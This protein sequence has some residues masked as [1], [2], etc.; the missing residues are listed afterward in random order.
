MSCK[1]CGNTHQENFCPVCGERKF[2]LKQLSVKHFIEETFEGFIHFDNKFLYTLK[3]LIFQ[4]GQLAVNY[5][6]GRRVKFMKPIQFFL[7]INILFFFLSIGNNLYRLPLN[8]YVNYEPFTN[9]NTRHIVQ[10]KLKRS[11]L[12]FAEY[13][14]IFNE[15][16]GSVSKEFIFIFIPFYGTLLFLLFFWKK[17]YFVEHLVFASHFVAFILLLNLIEFYLLNIPFYLIEKNNYVQ[18]FDTFYGIFTA[19]SIAMYMVFA[20]RKFYNPHLIYSILVSATIGY[21]FF[22]FIQY[23]RMLLFFKIL[24]LN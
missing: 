21:T 16:I 9:Y 14:Q 23:Y 1:S 5:T 15:R 24:Y 18:S 4:P 2:E 10:E 20:I 8:N 17:K 12:S 3:T 19:V 7:V 11:G 6:E 22:Y 13:T